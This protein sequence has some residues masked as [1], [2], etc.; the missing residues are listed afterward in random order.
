MKMKQNN[1]FITGTLCLFL[2]VAVIFA[3]VAFCNNS[4]IEQLEQRIS[5][6][7]Q[8][9][10]EIT[11]ETESSTIAIESTESQEQGVAGDVRKKINELEN[12]VDEELGDTYVVPKNILKDIIQ[13]L[14]DYFTFKN[15]SDTTTYNI[16]NKLKSVMTEDCYNSFISTTKLGYN[17]EKNQSESCEI[18]DINF[19]D[20]DT[21]NPKAL[22][23]V[24]YEDDYQSRIRVFDF[25]FDYNKSLEKYKISQLLISN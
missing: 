2:V 19:D 23:R 9:A 21:A 15:R 5:E 13:S 12:E 6:Q 24:N 22:V 20:I 18:R 7:E 4:K 1:R 8:I 17:D 25:E 16:N 14:C 10:T 11:A 3:I